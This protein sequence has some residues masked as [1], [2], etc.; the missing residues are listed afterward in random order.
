[1]ARELSCF[2]LQVR[3]MKRALICVLCLG[4]GAGWTAGASQYPSLT[5]VMD[6]KGPHSASSIREMQHEA[7]GIIKDSG[8]HLDW[9]TVEEAVQHSYVDLVVVH[10]RG[11]CIVERDPNIYYDELGPSG[12]LAFTYVTD[13]EIQPFSE[14]SCD[15]VA[16]SV[17]SA[18]LG[19]DFSKADV[20][21]GRAL[22]RVLAHELVHMLTK[23]E[24]HG[25][26][27]VQKAAL[28][29]K[30]LISGPLPLSPTDMIRLRLNY[31]AR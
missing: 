3:D 25:R 21:M 2:L 24:E 23:S 28:S 17:R 10:F 22:G 30:Q 14:V 5:V 16:A 8:V 31:S 20:L 13:G 19:D 27:G 1:M 7:Q 11:T 12:P 26:E 29:G 15:K 4:A 6:F 18:M 9:R